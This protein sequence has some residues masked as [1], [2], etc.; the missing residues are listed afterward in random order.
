MR[1]SHADGGIGVTALSQYPNE[2]AYYRLRRAKGAATAAFHM[3]PH[4]EGQVVACTRGRPRSSRVANL[5][6]RFRVQ[7]IAEAGRTVVRTKVWSD[8]AAEPAAWQIDCADTSAD[9]LGAGVPGV[10]SM[11]PGEKYWDDLEV[12]D[13]RRRQS[14]DAAAGRCTRRSDPPRALSRVL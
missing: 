2:D 9:R 13:D 10:W 11:G 7:A 5:W 12:V 14:T 6:Y 1:I 3:S 8:G 4:P